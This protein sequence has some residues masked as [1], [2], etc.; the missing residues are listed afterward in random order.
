MNIR[1]KI[2]ALLRNKVSAEDLNAVNELWNSALPVDTDM[3][4]DLKKFLLSKG[5]TAEDVK[6]ACELADVEPAAMDFLPANGTEAEGGMGGHMSGKRADREQVKAMDAAM[7][8]ITRGRADLE[9]LFPDAGL[10]GH[11]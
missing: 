3:D 1:E 9:K 8:K 4:G 6:R 2:E 7:D 11:I 10:I 5:L